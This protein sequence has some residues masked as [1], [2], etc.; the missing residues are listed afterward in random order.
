MKILF[1]AMAQSVH[2]ARWINQIADQG[3]D[4]HLFPSQDVGLHH[5]S[6][7]NIT[8]HHSISTPSQAPVSKAAN[9]RVTGLRVPSLPFNQAYTSTR[10]ATYARA[11]QETFGLGKRAKTLARLIAR[12]QPDLLHTI[13]FQHG[14]Y[15]TLAAQEYFG[16]HFPGRFPP[17][18]ITNYGHDLYLYRHL[19]AHRERLQQLLSRVDYY[20]C[21][22]QRDLN[23]AGRWGYRVRPG[24]FCP[25]L[26]ALTW[27]S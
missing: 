10:I 1:V 4:L 18:I 6:L 24:Q 23:I 15:L 5:T 2:V 22:C 21:E 26:A 27:P 16:R 12:L 17:W 7:R 8:I 11:A 25:T 13:E 14:G 20:T 9:R 19:K 3:W